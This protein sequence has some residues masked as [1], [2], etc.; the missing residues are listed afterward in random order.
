MIDLL[1]HGFRSE[2]LR[3]LQVQPRKGGPSHSQ[4]FSRTCKS[5]CERPQGCWWP[6]HGPRG[7]D[8][9]F[10]RALASSRSPKS[11]RRLYTGGRFNNKIYDWPTPDAAPAGKSGGRAAAV[12]EKIIAPKIVEVLV[13]ISEHEVHH[14]LTSEAEKRSEKTGLT[15]MDLI[16]LAIMSRAIAPNGAK[17]A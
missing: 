8:V 2:P 15:Q 16:A 3:L 14:S 6:G 11:I 17:S 9:A 7:S 12:I 13:L 1:S 4:P 10:L 5:S